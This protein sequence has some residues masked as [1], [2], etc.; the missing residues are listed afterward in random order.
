MNRSTTPIVRPPS[1]TE[2]AFERVR[3]GILTGEYP[4]GSLLS[5]QTIAQDLGISRTPIR[6]AFGRLQNEGL[7]IVV[8]QRGTMVFTMDEARFIEICDCR[9][10]LEVGA[11]KIA[12]AADRQG[13]TTALQ[14]AVDG[15]ERAV[16]ERDY[17][18]YI[19]LDV[20]FHQTFFDVANNR[21][22]DESYRLISGQMT[23]LR[24]RIQ[25]WSE[26][27]LRGF[28]D[29]KAMLAAIRKADLSS[30]IEILER[31]TRP[32]DGSFWSTRDALPTHEVSQEAS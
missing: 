19:D 13:L 9:A 18:S 24:Y 11:L 12:C 14:A 30:A 21:Y 31:H 15:M 25:Q 20:V 3:T 27:T 10:V 16:S 26:T 32:A 8:P 6:E 28:K 23:T 22:L 29:H 5:E 4:M 2:L 1:L 7:V 17:L